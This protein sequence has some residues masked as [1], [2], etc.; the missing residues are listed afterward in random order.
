MI[1]GKIDVTRIDKSRLFEGKKGTYLDFA[2]I[3]TPNNQYGD[4][5]MIVQDISK[6]EREAGKKGEVLGNA[7][8]IQAGG[9]RHEEPATATTQEEPDNVPF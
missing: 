2:L 5:F 7:K 3:D 4:D 8:I 6:E 9:Q 1:R